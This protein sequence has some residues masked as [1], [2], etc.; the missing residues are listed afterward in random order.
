[1]MNENYEELTPLINGYAYR[2]IGE[3]SLDGELCYV[4]ISVFKG[5]QVV[6]SREEVQGFAD[7][8]ID[9]LMNDAYFEKRKVV[10]YSP[11][12]NIVH[13]NDNQFVINWFVTPLFTNKFEQLSEYCNGKAVKVL[14]GKMQGHIGIYEARKTKNF[15]RKIEEYVSIDGVH[16]D[17]LDVDFEFVDF[18]DQLSW[19]S[20]M[21]E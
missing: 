4:K 5:T 10:N 18:H 11:D 6:T 1:M 20:I 13:E 7:L 21:E 16:Y 19:E 2:K 15:D 17:L 3:I 12:G 8:I 14:S 9:D